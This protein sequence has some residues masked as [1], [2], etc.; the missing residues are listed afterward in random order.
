MRRD[1]TPARAMSVGKPVSFPAREVVWSETAK[2]TLK[3]A[4]EL[5]V[6][7]AA[8]VLLSSARNPRAVIKAIALAFRS[9]WPTRSPPA[10]CWSARAAATPSPA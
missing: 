8:A 7:V 1:Q 10:G 6:T 2:E 9:M 3:F 4:L 5:A